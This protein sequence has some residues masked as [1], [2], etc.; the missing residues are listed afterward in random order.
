MFDTRRL[1]L[2]W[3]YREGKQGWPSSTLVRPYPYRVVC[4]YH[5]AA[6]TDL[7]CFCGREAELGVWVFFFLFLASL[8]GQ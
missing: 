5:P 7:F 1:A 6:I 3:S 4:P 8:R 2:V